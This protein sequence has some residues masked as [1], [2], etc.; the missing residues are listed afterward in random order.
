[1]RKFFFWL[2]LVQTLA[3]SYFFSIPVKSELSSFYCTAILIK[4][5]WLE[6]CSVIS[7]LWNEMN[8]SWNLEQHRIST[9]KSQTW[10]RMICQKEYVPTEIALVK[11][12]DSN[13][14]TTVKPQLYD[15][16]GTAP[17]H[18]IIWKMITD[19]L[20]CDSMPMY[21]SKVLQQ[22]YSR[23]TVVN[24]LTCVLG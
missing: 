14:R 23:V 8:R 2:S 5:P 1:M 3:N 11:L 9:G 16:C 4:R 19:A 24:Y 15:I 7:L 22:K 10:S 20:P 13:I 6:V 18:R 12:P 17:K 21:L